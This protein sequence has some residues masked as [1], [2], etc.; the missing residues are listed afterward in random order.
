MT[1]PL[2]PATL[3]PPG[4]RRRL[5]AALAAVA[6]G[7]GT[8]AAAEP[9]PPTAPWRAATAREC[10]TPTE[11]MWMSG[12]ASRDRPAEG[13]L[14]DLWAKALVLED[15]VGTRHVLVTLDLVGIDRDTAG[16]ITARLAER[17]G[18]PRAAVVIATSH[19]H[20][21]PVVRGNLRT[22]YALDDAAWALVRRYAERLE[23]TVTRIVGQALAEL[24]PADIAW[25]TARATFAV[26]RRTNPEKDVPALRAAG[27]LVGPVDH[28]AP[29]LVVRS[30]GVAGTAGVR[31]VV[32][33][34]ACHATVLSGYQWSGDWPGSAQAEL[35]RL[36]PG[37]TA[38]VWIGCGADQNPLPRRTVELAR[39]YGA[40]LAAAVA[41][42]LA[43]GARPVG[44]TLAAAQAEIPLEYAT[45]PTRA[46]IERAAGSDNRFEAAR[47]RLLLETL[48]RDGALAASYPYPVQTWRL[49][50]GPR[51]VFLGGEVVV[52][53]ALRLKADPGGDRTWVAAYSND[54]MAYV[55]S[56]RVLAEGG[57]EGGGAMVYYGLPAP[58]APSVE[59]AIIQ[60]VR[61]QI[62]ELAH[63][64]IP[65][66]EGR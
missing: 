65:T 59:E 17:H 53:Y 39:R 48:D 58:W 26:N 14:D 45:L 36:F 3:L 15:P 34:Y 7:C 2:P 41:D 49:G 46:E 60:A 11:P 23:E 33:G 61:N 44:G 32:V 31:A 64:A 16:R 50:D 27:R 62:A 29:V 21:G 30:P 13:T 5:L 52:D 4:A 20:S 1:A 63:P 12:Y 38:L 37:A 25:T 24:R 47:A 35:E 9:Q 56:R 55:P 22:M 8:A 66:E 40:D 43:E 19:T 10:I 18:L 42:A 6:V 54:V 28:D 51:W 57:Y